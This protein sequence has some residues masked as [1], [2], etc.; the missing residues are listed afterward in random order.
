M[1]LLRYKG[2][3]DEWHRWGDVEVITFS[4]KPIITLQFHVYLSLSD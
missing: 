1:A 3:Y 4:N 2:K